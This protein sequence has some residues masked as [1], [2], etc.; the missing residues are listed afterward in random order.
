[1]CVCLLQE[2]V[3][4]ESEERT[5][6]PFVDPVTVGMEKIAGGWLDKILDK[7]DTDPADLEEKME[8]MA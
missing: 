7:S 6:S 2:H 8:M 4:K 3:T 5:G 1:M